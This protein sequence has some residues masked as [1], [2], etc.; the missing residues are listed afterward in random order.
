MRI[1]SSITSKGVIPSLVRLL[2]AGRDRRLRCKAYLVR[3]V[4]NFVIGRPRFE[5]V[6][7]AV[8]PQDMDMM[9]EAIEQRAGETRDAENAGF[10]P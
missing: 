9:R 5:S 4:D 10:I 7:L 1:A 6:A 8:Q 2:L 3:Y